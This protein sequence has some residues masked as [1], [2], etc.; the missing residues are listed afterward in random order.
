MV[1]QQLLSVRVAFHT[2]HISE[3]VE[4]VLFNVCVCEF[5]ISLHTYIHVYIKTSKL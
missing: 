4:L 5:Y 1:F 3:T 2:H